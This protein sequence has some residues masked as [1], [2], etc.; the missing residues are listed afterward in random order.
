VL[1][2]TRAVCEFHR[3]D[4]TKESAA[5]RELENRRFDSVFVEFIRVIYDQSEKE[6]DKQIKMWRC[7]LGKA[8]YYSCVLLPGG[9]F[10]Y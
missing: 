4:K 9:L 5:I 7:K 2:L 3:Y 6:A 1:D 8:L 10:A